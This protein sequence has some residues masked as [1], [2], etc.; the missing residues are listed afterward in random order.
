MLTTKVRTDKK[1]LPNKVWPNKVVAEQGV[2][3]E[4]GADKHGTD[5]KFDRQ[6]PCYAVR[7]NKSSFDHFFLSLFQ[8]NR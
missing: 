4:S 1:C 2:A 8:W 5:K 7:E 3:E 6:N